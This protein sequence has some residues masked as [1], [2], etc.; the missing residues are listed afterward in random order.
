MPKVI[1]HDE[2]RGKLLSQCL[3]LFSHEGYGSLTMRKIAKALNVSTGTLYHYF[4]SKEDLFRQLVEYITH[5]DLFDVE[6]ALQGA[7]TFSE[8]VDALLRF[9]IDREDYFLNQVI[10]WMDYTRQQGEGT[11]AEPGPREA[12]VQYEQGIIRLLGIEKEVARFILAAINGLVIQ[13]YIDGGRTSLATQSILIRQY[14][15]GQEEQGSL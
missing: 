14:L 9:F 3:N 12:L 4:D 1:N 15:L 8:R 5:Q 10:I 11:E 2:V 13:R 7:D 6:K